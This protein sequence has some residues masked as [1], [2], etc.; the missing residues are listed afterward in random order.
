MD[1]DSSKI[2]S[3]LF[4]VTIEVPS[5]NVPPPLVSTAKL[6]LTISSRFVSQ[7]SKDDDEASMYSVGNGGEGNSSD[8]EEHEE[9][10]GHDKYFPEGI[11][12]R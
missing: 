1:I 2:S 9:G 6:T 10:A 5:T 12:T 11:E 7:G 3:G 4:S 8:E